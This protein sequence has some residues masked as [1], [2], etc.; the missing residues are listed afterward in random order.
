MHVQWR[1]TIW[2][3]ANLAHL[4]EVQNSR[5]KHKKSSFL[6]SFYWYWGTTAYIRRGYWGAKWTKLLISLSMLF[7]CCSLSNPVGISPTIRAVWLKTCW[8]LVGC[9]L[10]SICFHGFYISSTGLSSLIVIALEINLLKVC[11]NCQAYVFN[12]HFADKTSGD[13]FS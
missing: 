12:K 2:S 8:L 4:S 13:C 7:S 1:T 5:R 3:K 6:S 10:F 11:F 9:L